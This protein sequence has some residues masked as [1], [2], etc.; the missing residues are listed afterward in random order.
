MNEWHGVS[1]KRS[2]CWADSVKC[3]AHQRSIV[4][5]WLVIMIWQW[6]QA[7]FFNESKIRSVNIPGTDSHYPYAFHVF[8]PTSASSFTMFHRGDSY[9]LC[10]WATALSLSRA[11]KRLFPSAGSLFPSCH[12]FLRDPRVCCLGTAA[13]IRAGPFPFST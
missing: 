2:P 5:R 4:G 9:L 11:A 7:A 13:D 3:V 8:I 10:N 1:T 12:S 6:V